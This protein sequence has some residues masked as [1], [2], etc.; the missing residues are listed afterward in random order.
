MIYLDRLVNG[1]F[2][3]LD[4]F[5]FSYYKLIFLLIFIYSSFLNILIVNKIYA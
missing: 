3:I 4:I 1:F 2:Y 5:Y